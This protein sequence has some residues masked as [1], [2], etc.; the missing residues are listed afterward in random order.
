MSDPIHVTVCGKYSPTGT[1]QYFEE[2]FEESAEVDYL[3]L[4][5]GKER[6][7]YPRDV[8]VADL[9]T[10]LFLYVDEWRPIFPRGLEEIDAPTAAFFTDVCYDLD[11]RLRMAPFFDHLFVAHRDYL[12]PF[13][14][15]HPSVH[16]LPFASGIEVDDPQAGKRNLEIA[17][18]GGAGGERLSWLERLEQAFEINDFRQRYTLDEVRDL[19]S[20]A[21]IVF[22]KGAADE[23]N[24]RVFEGPA[25]GALLVTN[26]AAG[27]GELFEPGEEIVTYEDFTEARE[28]IRY[29]L[30]HEDER[31]RIATAGHERASEDHTFEERI[32]DIAG[33]VESGRREAPVRAYDEGQ[34][35][36]A[37]ARVYASFPMLDEL[38]TLLAESKAPLPSRIKAVGH[39][40]RGF[41][42]GW[43]RM[44]WRRFIE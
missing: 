12:D 31:R 6:P 35:L 10:D 33:T 42:R 19:Y 38:R 44:G 18:V 40:A 30:Q 26:E 32:R 14:E 16:W 1:L 34:A 20:R 8:D 15:I 7:G 9:D 39:A 22:N 29:Y 4:P 25:C 27:L 2:A 36:E 24:F 5:A 11:H 41:A 17:F 23:I 43:R 28:K 3:G 37:Y 13:R 21:R